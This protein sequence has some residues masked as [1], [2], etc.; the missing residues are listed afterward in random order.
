MIVNKKPQDEDY[1][2]LCWFLLR[3]DDAALNESMG[4]HLFSAFRADPSKQKEMAQRL[5]QFP[6]NIRDR[7]RA[8]LIDFMS[9]DI[10]SY[11]GMLPFKEDF[12]Y[13]TDSVSLSAVASLIAQ[14]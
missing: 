7:L 3:S 2:L 11:T 8:G 14:Q 4:E 12:P 1:S 6:G 5:V 13:F 9:I 10:E